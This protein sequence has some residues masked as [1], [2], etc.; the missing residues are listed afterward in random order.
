MT[1][2]QILDQRMAQVETLAARRAPGDERYLAGAR[3]LEAHSIGAVD[4]Q[5]LAQ[6]TADATTITTEQRS[7]IALRLRKAL[8]AGSTG[9]APTLA[10][11]AAL[12]D[13]LEA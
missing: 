8:V 7:A 2:Q 9:G 5:V 12:I 1:G 3:S 6:W 4:H 10:T 13:M 11:T